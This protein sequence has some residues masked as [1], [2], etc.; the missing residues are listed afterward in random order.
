MNEYFSCGS[1]VAI[2]YNHAVNGIIT[3]ICIRHGNVT[4]EVSYFNS[5]EYKQ[6]WLTENEFTVIN[7]DDK[8]KIGFQK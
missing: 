2:T 5:G 1:K 7:G 4:Y 6:I 3:C 8:I